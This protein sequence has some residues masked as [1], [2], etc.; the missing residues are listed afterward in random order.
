MTPCCAPRPPYRLC[1]PQGRPY[2]LWDVDL[3][4]DPVMAHLRS[5]DDATRLYWTGVVLRQAKPDDAI[6]LLGPASIQS[7]VPRLSGRL[8]RMEPFWTWLTERWAGHG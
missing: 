7:A 5:P 8:G 1:D 6:V 3:T 4:L 2:F